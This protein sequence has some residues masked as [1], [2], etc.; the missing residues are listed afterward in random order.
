MGKGRLVHACGSVL[1]G[2]G[3]IRESG[4][5]HD[6]A[7]NLQMV[8]T[9]S[10]APAHSLQC[11]AMGAQWPG[12]VRAVVAKAVLRKISRRMCSRFKPLVLLLQPSC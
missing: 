5:Q 9:V 3:T 11:L 12:A 6:D 7:L 4:L 8:V 10:W 2:A 1:D